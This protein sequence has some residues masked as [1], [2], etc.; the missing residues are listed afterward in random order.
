MMASCV[1][2]SCNELLQVVNTVGTVS[3]ST[4]VTNTENIAGLK[5]ALNVGIED[6]VKSLGGTNGFF[7]NAALK[8]LLPPEAQVV[9]DNIKLIPGGQQLVENAILSLNRSAEDAVREATPIF[10]SAITS[11]TITDAAGILFGNNNAATS[12]LHNKTYNQLKGAFAPKVR[13]SLDKPFVANLSTYETWSS[14]TSAYNSVANTPVG[15][16][17]GLK[18][19]NVDLGEYVTE[20]ALD[21]LF[22]KI[23]EEEKAIRVNPAARVNQVL[24][25]VFGQLDNK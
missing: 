22:T 25:R 21:A 10:K 6:A 2:M 16:I 11:M 7:N 5:S 4:G 9:V 14:L 12:Y 19:V 13:A 20:K 15:A 3:T 8:I 18:S 1:F 23:A 24:K 17:A